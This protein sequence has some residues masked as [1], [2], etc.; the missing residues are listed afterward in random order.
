MKITVN[1]LGPIKEG[2]ITFN[3]GLTILTGP[4]NMGK[5]Y[6]TYLIYGIANFNQLTNG[7]H[8][9]KDLS[10][11]F[12]KSNFL[13]KKLTEDGSIHLEELVS[14]HITQIGKIINNTIQD[15]LVEIF[16]SDTIK[17]KIQLE[18]STVNLNYRDEEYQKIE[19]LDGELNA[20]LKSGLVIKSAFDDTL[21]RI[22]DEQSITKKELSS[23]EKTAYIAAL[24]LAF[25]LTTRPLFGRAFFFPAERTAINLFAK[26]IIAN[27][28]NK[29]SIINVK[30][31]AGMK[32]AELAR[33]LMKEAKEGPKYPYAINDYI[34]FVNSFTP[35]KKEGKFAKIANDLEELIAG[36]SISITEFQQVLFTP[37]G[38]KE[39][40][41][42]HLSSSLVKSLSYISLYLRYIARPN[43]L[44]I[45]D[46][47]ELNLH[48]NLQIAIAKLLAEMV[49][50]GLQVII[51]TH[52]DYLIKELNNLVLL[53]GLNQ[54]KKHRAF[55]KSKAYNA[56]HLLGEEQVDAYFL[57]DHGI[58]LIDVKAHGIE[59]PSIN[60]AINS[61]DGLTEEILFQ[62]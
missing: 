14:H 46:E 58:D 10:Q 12:L 21:L 22:K 3:K 61:L 24:I 30:L 5:S 41:D 35:P 31:T 55:I 43:D 34:N 1:N 8:L 15:N 42:L 28:A 38:S 47:P 57:N 17:A 60:D 33:L 59:V 56:K 53:H 25:D 20:I 50:A 49:N 44:V 26:D 4:N 18:M 40:L 36:G 37:I 52:S 13:Q 16:A 9:E 19:V 51:S 11:L 2:K 48:P 29:Q 45:I 27:R 7:R 54:S 39:A 23:H 6:L 32:K 62:D